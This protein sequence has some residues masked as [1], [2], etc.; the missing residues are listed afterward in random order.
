[1]VPGSPGTPPGLKM[2]PSYVG[3][4]SFQRKLF[5]ESTDLEVFR[6]LFRTASTF[7]RGGNFAYTTL[8]DVTLTLQHITL[9]LQRQ[10][11]VKIC[12]HEY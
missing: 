1:M 4:T 8:Q 3:G 10:R 7:G 9:M 6:L 12:S 5:E 11:G 2:A